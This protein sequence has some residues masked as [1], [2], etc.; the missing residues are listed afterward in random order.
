[1]IQLGA[2]PK[3]YSLIALCF[4]AS[5]ICYIDR[6]SI[7]VAVLAMQE[8]F[9]WSQTIKGVVLSSFFVGYL[10]LQIP[11]GYLA[12]RF[13]GRLVLAVAVLWWSLCTILTPLSAAVSLTLLIITRV[14]MGAGEAA[15]F[16][17][18]YN[19]FSRWTVPAERA[20]AVSLLLSGIPV[21]TVFALSVTGWVVQQYDW[22]VIFYIF[23]SIGI[24]WAVV[25]LRTVHD[26]PLTHPTITAS[27]R[28]LLSNN[29]VGSKAAVIPWRALLRAPPVYALV[30][31]HFCSNW[32]LY[33][34][35]TWLP[36]YFRDS[37]GLSIP[38]AGLYSA[39]PWLT[40][41]VMVNVAAWIAD[42]MVRRGLTLTVVRKSMQS[43]GLLG[44]AVFL[45]LARDTD[46][47]SA[48]LLVMC[49]ALGMLAF[50][51]SGFAPN[52]L[53]IAPRYADVLMG[54]T[55]TFGTLPGVLGVVVTGW[56]LDVTGNY[57]DAFLL[58]A[59]INVAGALVWL[60][61]ATGR[62]VVD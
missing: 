7:S 37:Q 23:G 22:P 39:A 40:M 54:I 8:T 62:R 19:L 60:I 14:A 38:T 52:H 2:W 32:G 56:L 34:L 44:S 24:V 11:S 53:D 9:G 17:G 16:P 55:N 41:F 45:L 4:C 13:G 28:A 36:S 43:I 15:M 31:N 6:V 46:S 59:L 50:T 1:M 49:G 10:L 25:W 26:S 48:A 35:M 61:F 5:F 3:R 57:A 20:R 27:E 42:H 29:S 12:N 47:A 51:W 18:A 33:M 21:G 30:I 58:A